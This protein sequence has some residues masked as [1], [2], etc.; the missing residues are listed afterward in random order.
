MWKKQILLFLQA[1]FC[2]QTF[3]APYLPM[4]YY[5]QKPKNN[6]M[7]NIRRVLLFCNKNK[8]CKFFCKLVTYLFMFFEEKKT[9]LSVQK[10]LLTNTRTM[11]A[12]WSLFSLKSQTFGLEQTIWADKVLG[13]WCIFGRFISMQFGTLSPLSMLSINHSLILYIQIPNIL[14]LGF[15]FGPQRI[16][17]LAIV[18]P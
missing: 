3:S 6:T 16:R 2:F 12:Q 7:I 13:L 17:D 11:D 4:D 10:Y 9:F 15:E 14:G 1:L 8:W 5:D 18:C